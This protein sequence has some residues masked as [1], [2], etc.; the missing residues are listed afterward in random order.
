MRIILSFGL[1]LIFTLAH[2][3]TA[4]DAL[5][6]S[7]LDGSGISTA[8]SLGSGGALSALGTDFSVISTNPAGLGW[9]RRSEF[10]ITP[11][12][13]AVGTESKL[14]DS[15][16]ALV[17][18]ERISKLGISNLGIVIASSPSSGQWT[19]FNFGIGLN[20]LANFNQ[21]FFYDGQSAGSII[22]RFQELANGSESL[23]D[24]ESGLAYD[25]EAL[26]DFNSDG[27]YDSDVELRPNALIYKEQTVT[28]SGSLNELAFSF[29]G[30]YN[31]KLML[32]VTIG[33]PF[34]NYTAD[35]TYKESDKGEDQG[36]NVPFFDDLEFTESLTTTGIGINLK[37]GLIYRPIQAVRLGVAFHTPTAFGLDDTYRNT[38]NYFYTDSDGS[39][40]GSAES[41][42][43]LFDYKF[44]S[45]WRIIG[46]LGIVVGKSG[47]LSGEIEWADYTGA[48]FGYADFPDDERE[49]NNDIVNQLQAA[50][51]IRLGGEFVYDIFRLRAGFG[52]HQS[53]LQGDDTVNESISAGF[54]IREKSFFLDLGYRHY[55]VEETYTPYLTSEAPM[56][57]VNNDVTNGRFLLSLGFRF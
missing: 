46:G 21:R 22:N 14:L 37:A 25:A 9:Y 49:V 55:L 7:Y 4:S 6:F 11:S 36:G 41:P 57:F 54:G 5:R 42:D 23:D 10:V 31:D 27:L 51:N 29:A 38:M 40:S 52:L 1:L 3:Q 16:D 47:F 13:T 8:R 32:G 28:T 30:S 12:L 26:Y 18:R 44:R 24:F 20:Q 33:V 39:K 2:S 50:A 43:G 56:Q 15:E 35:K 19:T 34:L 17:N 53:P 48:Q 45:P